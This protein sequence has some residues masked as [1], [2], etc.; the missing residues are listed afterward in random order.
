VTYT[1]QPVLPFPVGDKGHNIIVRPAFT[2]SFNQPIFDASQSQFTELDTEFNDITFDTV[3][4]GNT[5]KSPGHGYLW[6]VGVAGTLPTA[7]N[8]A[9]GGE[10]WRLGPELFGGILRDWGVAGALVSN[11]WNIGGGDGGPGSNDEPFSTT[12]VQYFYGIGLGNAWQILSGPVITYD[13]KA[14]SGERLALPLGT[15]IAKTLKIGD[16]TWRFQLEIQYYVKQPDSF[17]TEWLLSFDFRPVIQ[18][19]VL[20]WFQ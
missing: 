2:L 19:P 17:G 6:G 1:F 10:Q 14:D 15:G 13:W 9:L 20:K 12:V 16:T 3:Y 7:S 8:S 18:N 5:M 11:Q 4:A